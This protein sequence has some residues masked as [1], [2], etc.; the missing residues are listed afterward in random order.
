MLLVFVSQC[1]KLSWEISSP[2]ETHDF[3]FNVTTRSFI[4]LFD[5]TYLERLLLLMMHGLLLLL[6]LLLGLKVHIISDAVHVAAAGTS[7]VAV[8]VVAAT[9]DGRHE[10]GEDRVDAATQEELIRPFV[11]ARERSLFV[12]D[13]G[14]ADTGVAVGWVSIVVKKNTYR[15][16]HQAVDAA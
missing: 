12:P 8:A 10:R 2:V 4:E 6:L 14:S 15:G 7:A 11:S 5:S 1:D 3:G 9:V 16:P 13:R